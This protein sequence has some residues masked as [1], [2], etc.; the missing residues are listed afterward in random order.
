MKIKCKDCGNEFEFS[1]NEQKWY[2]EHSFP[3][4]KRCS[5]CRRQRKNQIERRYN[6]GK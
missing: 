5:Y 4:P 1:E 6:N 2:E 3:A